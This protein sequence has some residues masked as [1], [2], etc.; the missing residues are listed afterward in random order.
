MDFLPINSALILAGA[1]LFGRA[2]DPAPANPLTAVGGR[3]LFQ[4]T[5]L[6]LERGGI[7]RFVVLAG[8]ETEALKRQVQGNGRVRADVRWLPVREF[9]PGDPR[10]WEIFSGM[11][12]G[13]YLVAGT[14]AVFPA[15]LVARVREAGWAGEPVVVVRDAVLRRAQHERLTEEA[16]HT[17]PVILSMSKGETGGVMIVETAVSP[18]LDVELAVMPATFASPGWAGG[19]DEAYP[20]QAVIERGLRRG[21]VRVLPLGEDWYQDVCAE[22]PATR[23]QAEWTLLKDGLD[24]FVGRH[25]NRP[26]PQWITRLL[27]QI[28][29]L[30]R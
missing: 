7:S 5:L 9:P 20:V 17:T 22:G 2:G 13:P 3:S 19:P 4:R 15:S 8:A 14:S 26:C 12:G 6:T 25:F 11:F 28:I 1:R 23:A 30:L 18:A 29:H 21:Q 27:R 10:T 16:S 24:R